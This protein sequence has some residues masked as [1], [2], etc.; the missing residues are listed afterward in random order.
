MYRKF[1]IAALAVLIAGPAFAA[2]GCSSAPA[3]KF[4]PKAS[5]AA[6]LKAEGLTVRQIK[7]ESGCYEVYALDK[8]GRRVNAAYN[9][10]TFQ[11]LANAEAGER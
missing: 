4:K 6:K 9:A 5:L 11:K 7:V 3:S 2:G 1:A 10:E 8:H